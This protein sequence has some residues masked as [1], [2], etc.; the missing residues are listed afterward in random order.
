M[1]LTKTKPR[2][3]TVAVRKR[4][5]AH[6]QHSHR[7]KQAYWPYLPIIAIMMFGLALNNWMGTSGR[8]VLGYATNMSVAGLLS[9][10]N[11]E[12]NANNLGN[13]ALSATLNQAAQNK[14]NDM[15][16]RDYWSH[17]TP[18]GQAPWTFITAVGYSYQTAGENLA[19]GFTASSD[20]ITGWMNSPGHRANILNS[21]FSEVGFGVANSPNYVGNGPQTVVVAMYALP[22]GGSPP[23]V[24]TPAPSP[25]PAPAPT[26]APAP[27][28]A[29]KPAP[30]AS[31]NSGGGSPQPTP[32]AES[33]IA[34]P[35]PSPEPVAASPVTKQ[36]D[37][38]AVAKSADET[39]A[40]KNTPRLHT[41]AATNVG[42]SQFAVSMLASVALLAFLLRHSFAWHKVLVK[43]EKF[44]VRHP[45]LDII[46]VAV[47]TLGFILLQSSG[48]IR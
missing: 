17:N 9:G 16:A 32:P 42:W 35:T 20:T 10:T 21:S 30:S 2:K 37:S 14:A 45:F 29:P 3:A 26:A 1:T 33:P 44:I 12:R 19:F 5:A 15:V 4:T 39:V 27:T 25:A 34:E 40:A 36:G 46:F 28:P 48:T 41:I 24:P 6:H 43:G 38:D 47:A 7:Y 23:A 18:D 13:L 22:I 11:V 31:N 8:N